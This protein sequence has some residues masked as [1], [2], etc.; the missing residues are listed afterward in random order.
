M[1]LQQLQNE[2]A[3]R[4]D[5]V[6][7]ADAGGSYLLELGLEPDWLIGDFDSLSQEKCVASLS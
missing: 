5:L 4:P 2:M 7:A 6:I 3:P 1:V